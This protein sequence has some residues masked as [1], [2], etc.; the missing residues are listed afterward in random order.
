[1]N[2]YLFYQL[3]VGGYQSVGS[4]AVGS[5]QQAAGSRAVGSRQ[6]SA[7]RLSGNWQLTTLSYFLQAGRLQVMIRHPAR[8]LGQLSVVYCN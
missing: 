5:R 4:R 8:F 2:G 3:S 1:M 7:V 6:Q